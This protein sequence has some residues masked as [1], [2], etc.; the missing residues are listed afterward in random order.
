MEMTEVCPVESILLYAPVKVPHVEKSSPHS[1]NPVY[2]T[3]NV[4][5]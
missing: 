4:M 1:L 3:D 2:V 5:K